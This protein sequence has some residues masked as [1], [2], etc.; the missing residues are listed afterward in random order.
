M[1]AADIREKAAR[2]FQVVM[3][4]DHPCVT[5]CAGGLIIDDPQRAGGIDA[6]FCPDAPQGIADP[7]KLLTRA[8]GGPAGDDSVAG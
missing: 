3:I 7:L 1:G 4:G 5:Q 2:R 8:D 6:G